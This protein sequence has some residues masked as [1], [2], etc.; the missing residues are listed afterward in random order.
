MTRP[1]SAALPI[2]YVMLRILIVLNWIG[3]VLIV[4]LLV[5]IPNH[6]WIMSAFQIA[7]SPDAERLI[8][9]LRAVAVIGLV[10]VPINYLI[11]KRLIAIIETVRGGDPFVAANAERLQQIAWALLSLQ[12]LGL[13]IAA[14]SKA[15]S[16][17]ALRVDLD[18]FSVN[19]H[20]PCSSPS[21]LPGCSRSARAEN[22]KGRC[23]MAIAVKPTTCSTTGG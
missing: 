18:L 17:R 13:V 20:S 3:C 6:A 9:G 22:P 1:Y 12:L 23:D 11:L 15:I 14:I 21:C 2:A 10:M 19:G 7:A 16:T 5:A 4:A 8:M